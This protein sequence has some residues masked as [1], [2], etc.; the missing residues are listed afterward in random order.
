[1]YSPQLDRDLVRHLYFEARARGRSELFSALRAGGINAAQYSAIMNARE[2]A[3]YDMV[4]RVGVFGTNYI[5]GFRR[6]RSS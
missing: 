2:Q 1:H 5:G 4:K 6:C 3:R